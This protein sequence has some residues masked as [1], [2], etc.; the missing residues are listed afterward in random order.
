MNAPPSLLASIPAFSLAS[1]GF[2][3]FVVFHNGVVPREGPNAA[4]Y[5]WNK[6][7]RLPRSLLPVSTPLSSTYYPG[8]FFTACVPCTSCLVL[9]MVFILA[10]I[11]WKLMQPRIC[12]TYWAIPGTKES[13]SANSLSGPWESGRHLWFYLGNSEMLLNAT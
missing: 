11:C 1:A 3:C 6:T 9:L 13:D 2:I 8:Q 5:N 4:K 7:Q 12:T 10:G